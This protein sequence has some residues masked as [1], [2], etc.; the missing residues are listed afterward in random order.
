MAGYRVAVQVVTATPDPDP[1]GS[2]RLVEL[3]SRY[4]ALR[5]SGQGRLRGL[6]PFCGSTAF[7]V[8]PGHGTFHCFG[9]GQGGDGRVFAARIERP[10]QPE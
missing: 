7:N 6:C 3:V 5:P 10:G 8:R 9:C 4:T 1:D 2:G